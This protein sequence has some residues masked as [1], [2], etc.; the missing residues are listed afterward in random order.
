MSRSSFCLDFGLRYTS[1]A[2]RGILF[3]F[4][5]KQQ[6]SCTRD[7]GAVVSG[8]Q[9]NGYGHIRER[10]AKTAC[11]MIKLCSEMGSKSLAI[12]LSVFKYLLPLPQSLWAPDCTAPKESVASPSASV[13]AP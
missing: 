12:Y 6:A 1:L 7:F 13:H 4:Q 5:N 2:A 11:G 10:K 9:M 8:A 3:L